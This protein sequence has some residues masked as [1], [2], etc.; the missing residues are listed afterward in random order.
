[1]TC[2]LA[3]ESGSLRLWRTRA[4]TL[5]VSVTWSSCDSFDKL[6]SSRKLCAKY[7]GK[8]C[9]YHDEKW[10]RNL[11]SSQ[12]RICKFLSLMF[13]S[14]EEWSASHMLGYR[15]TKRPALVADSLCRG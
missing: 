2:G 3:S 1:M 12:K 10:P 8:R 9:P 6:G 4:S 7:A 15:Q 11:H 5:I 14:T 13:C